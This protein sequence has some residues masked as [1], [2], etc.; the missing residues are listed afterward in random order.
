MV[1]DDEEFVYIEGLKVFP[2]SVDEE[3]IWVGEEGFTCDIR[4][5]LFTLPDDIRVEPSIPR[6][7]MAVMDAKTYYDLCPH[8]RVHIPEKGML[9]LLEDYHIYLARCCNRMVW[10]AN[11]GSKNTWK[12]WE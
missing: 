4:D 3:G 2:D 12:R 10:V 5:L 6:K 11:G 9:L 1:P 8:C 7:V